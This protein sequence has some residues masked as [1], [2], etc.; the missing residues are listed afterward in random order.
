[1]LPQHSNAARSSQQ[2]KSRYL[3]RYKFK[4]GVQYRYE[5]S[6]SSTITLQRADI[7]QT[8]YN[9]ARTETVY[10][11]VG[12]DEQGNATI[13][14]VIKKVNMKAGADNQKPIVFDSTKGEDKC[15]PAFTPILKVINRP[16][17]KLTVSPS[18]KLLHVEPTGVLPASTDQAAEQSRRHSERFFI[19]FPAQPVAVGDSWT[20]DF[21]V[22]A[23]DCT[24][25]LSRTIKLRRRYRLTS[26]KD[27]VAEI[28]FQ[29]GPLTPIFSPATEAEL[30]PV[31]LHGTIRFDIV[32]GILLSRVGRNESLV[33]GAFG[34]QTAVQTK[35]ENQERLLEVIRLQ[36]NSTP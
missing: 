11:T 12:L 31:E 35:V 16:L 14:P 26:V 24:T 33:V 7:K 3:L 21:E 13:E 6:R 10:R 25:R 19:Q 15:P 18:G 4:T 5:I 9:T 34:P 8:T 23:A 2:T 36:K 32:R 20:Q 29:T 1:M 28:E 22:R 30:A 17:V 27:G